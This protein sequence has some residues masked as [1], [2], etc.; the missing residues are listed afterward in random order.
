MDAKRTAEA[1][2]VV[3]DTVP[4]Y[5]PVTLEHRTCDLSLFE[6][7]SVCPLSDSS[8]SDALP[9]F[10]PGPFVN[11]VYIHVGDHGH[12]LGQTRR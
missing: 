8:A 10:T 5:V 12:D 1:P 7:Y 6:C 3:S 2:H 9:P 4:P 11:I